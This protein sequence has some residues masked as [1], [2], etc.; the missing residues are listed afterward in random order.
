MT[1]IDFGVQ[2][3]VQSNVSYTVHAITFQSFDILLVS[4]FT[5]G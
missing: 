2:S 3:S 5:T 4:D 1:L